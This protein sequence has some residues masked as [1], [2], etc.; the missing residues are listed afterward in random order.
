[1]NFQLVTDI[2]N[3]SSIFSYLL[4]LVVGVLT[5]IFLITSASLL[6]HWHYY[7]IGFFRRWILIAV[8]GGIGLALLVA[9]YGLM[10]KLIS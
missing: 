5:L 3:G 6:Y 7:G 2:L 10:F 9:S 1:M 4:M 8:F